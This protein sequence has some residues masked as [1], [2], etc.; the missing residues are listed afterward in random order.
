VSVLSQKGAYALVYANSAIVARQSKVLAVVRICY[1]SDEDAISLA[2]CDMGESQRGYQTWKAKVF[3]NGA[4]MDVPFVSGSLMRDLVK[5]SQ[6]AMGR[7]KAEY[8]KVPGGKIFKVYRDAQ[9]QPVV[10]DLGEN[11]GVK[12]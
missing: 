6:T 8:G 5:M 4:L 7:I 11:K 12:A 2:Y 9:N 1:G 3:A 10:Q